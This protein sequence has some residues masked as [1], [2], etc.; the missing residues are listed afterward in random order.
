MSCVLAARDRRGILILIHDCWHV[1]SV[2]QCRC[3]FSEYIQLHIRSLF[4]MVALY[5]AAHNTT[6]A[7]DCTL[8]LFQDA[9]LPTPMLWIGDYNW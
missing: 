8:S 3:N 2:E 1:H 6:W 5:R 4:H 9:A 7:Y